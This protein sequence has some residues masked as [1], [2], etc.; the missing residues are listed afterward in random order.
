M[1]LG[2]RK[3]LQVKFKGVRIKESIAKE[4]EKSRFR[5][6]SHACRTDARIHWHKIMY[7]VSHLIPSLEKL[8]L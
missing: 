1:Q 3:E 7:N 5:D 2:K 4:L 6:G 8:L